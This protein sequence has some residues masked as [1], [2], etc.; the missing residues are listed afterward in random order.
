MQCSTIRGSN[1]V[2]DLE[3]MI[4]RCSRCLY[5]EQGAV[6]DWLPIS[7]FG[8]YNQ[9]NCWVL[10]IN[11][12]DREFVDQHG[13]VLTGDDQRFRR[14]SDFVGAARREDLTADHVSAKLI[15][16]ETVFDRVP[17]KPYFNRLGRFL[18]RLHGSDLAQAPLSPF[19]DGL[20]SPSGRKFLYTHLD[21]VKCATHVPWGRLS[22]TEQSKMIRNCSGF[23]EDQVSTN[24]GLEFVLINGRTAFNQYH[25]VL[26]ERF[27]FTPTRQV[28]DLGH[29]SC[30]LWIGDLNIGSQIVKVV[31]WSSNVVNQQ[32]RTSAIDRL[33]SGIQSACPFLC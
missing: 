23:L 24:D 2:A 4:A 14:L 15:Y 22:A 25:A 28:L 18:I 8:K 30:D 3:T 5:A 9:A 21:I 1:V 20:I 33:V 19:G 32:L 7:F 10:S 11:P 29:T 16:Q 6:K 31:G 12:S 27:G 17:Y 26:A 13:Q